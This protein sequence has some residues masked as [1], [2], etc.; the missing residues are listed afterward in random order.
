MEGLYIMFGLVFW[1]WTCYL[2]YG[3]GYTEGHEV[4]SLKMKHKCEVVNKF[5]QDRLS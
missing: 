2:C 5:M 1:M 4:G 3:E